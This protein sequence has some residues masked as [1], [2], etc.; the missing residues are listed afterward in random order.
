MCVCVFKVGEV[1]LNNSVSLENS[2]LLL[3]VCVYV[4]ALDVIYSVHKEF[5]TFRDIWYA[6]MCLFFGTV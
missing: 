1:G 5:L 4:V 3:Y 2:V 6:W